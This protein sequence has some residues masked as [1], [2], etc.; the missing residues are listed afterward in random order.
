MTVVRFPSQ[1]MVDRRYPKKAK[2]RYKML[3]VGSF[4][5]GDYVLPSRRFVRRLGRDARLRITAKP[6]KV[7]D[8]GVYVRAHLMHVAGDVIAL[9]E[10]PNGG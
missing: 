4:D 2:P 9:R 10:V 7:K 8:F 1:L 5:S 6:V 3:L